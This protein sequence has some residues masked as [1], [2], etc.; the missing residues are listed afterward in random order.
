MTD[1]PKETYLRKKFTQYMSTADKELVAETSFFENLFPMI[2]SRRAYDLPQTFFNLHRSAK[3]IGRREEVSPEEAFNM[4][5]QK[6]AMLLEIFDVKPSREWQMLQDGKRTGKE[7]RYRKDRIESADVTAPKI[8]TDIDTAGQFTQAT[9]AT[10]IA[11][12]SA[13][14]PSFPDATASSHCPA[15]KAEYKAS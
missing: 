8:T 11:S 15:L 3:I 2:A 9:E 1:G 14:T 13:T 12:P 6:P 7:H 5:L 10:D 4:M